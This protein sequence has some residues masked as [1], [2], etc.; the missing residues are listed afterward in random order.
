MDRQSVYSLSIF[1]RSA[2]EQ[3]PNSRGQI[4]QRLIDFVLEFQLDN[5]FIYR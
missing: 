4:Q 3:E 5:I 2:Q 1:G